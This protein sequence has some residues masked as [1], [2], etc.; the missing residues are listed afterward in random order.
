MKTRSFSFWDVL[1]EVNG[2][3]PFG[4]LPTVVGEL[5]LFTT[6]PAIANAV[7]QVTGKRMRHM[8]I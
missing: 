7:Q 4:D 1:E 2:I 3:Q 8:D 6:A 5:R